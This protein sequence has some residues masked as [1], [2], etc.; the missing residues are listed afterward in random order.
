M[1]LPNK[2]IS[3]DESVLSKLYIIISAM[4]NDIAVSELYLKVEKKLNGID[5][6]IYAIDTLYVLNYLDVDFSTRTVKYVN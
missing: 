5:E 3:F 4:E 1:L 2:F 6:F